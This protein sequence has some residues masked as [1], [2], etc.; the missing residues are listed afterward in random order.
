MMHPIK[1][2]C[3][4]L[5]NRLER[6][7]HIESEFLDKSE[8]D[9][10]IVP[11]IQDTKNGANGLY[12]TFINIL[13]LEMQNPSPN[14]YFVFAEDDHEFLNSYSIEYLLHNIEVAN[15]F[16]AHVLVG[17]PTFFHI[18]VQCTPNLFWIKVF[19]GT[20]FTIIF[21]RVFKLYQR[22]TRDKRRILDVSIS[23]IC[24]KIFTMYPPISAQKDFGYSDATPEHY[25]SSGEY[26][27]RLSLIST[28]RLS[29]IN[30]LRKVLNQD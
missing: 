11:A 17:G 15:T 6:R 2:Y 27:K 24:D 23:E 10:I 9:L 8:F 22:I 20:Q 7:K 4:N 29:T 14:G 1:V 30:Q 26:T 18:P 25:V 5:A 28:R 21:H 13:N 16:E 12:Q 3:P 19:N